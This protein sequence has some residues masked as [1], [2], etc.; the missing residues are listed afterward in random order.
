MCMPHSPEMVNEEDGVEETSRLYP[1][2]T[3]QRQP[4]PVMGAHFSLILG[5]V[6]ILTLL[7]GERTGQGSEA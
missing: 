1:R 4:T 3:H 5:E 6:G 2:S 7:T